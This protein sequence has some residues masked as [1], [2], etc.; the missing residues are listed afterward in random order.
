MSSQSNRRRSKHQ[1]KKKTAKRKAARK[2]QRLVKAKP[3]ANA[4]KQ[5]DGPPKTFELNDAG[6]A[7]RFADRCADTI[8]FCGPL[9]G[10]LHNGGPRWK[11]VGSGILNFIIECAR[12]MRFDAARTSEQCLQT[13]LYRHADRSQSS[14]RINACEKLARGLMTVPHEQ[15]DQKPHL[16]NVLNG[17]IDLRSGTLSPHD[18][19]DMLTQI[20]PVQFDESATCPRFDEFLSKFCLGR[21]DLV[22]YVLQ[23]LGYACTG[24]ACA[25]NL[26]LLLGSGDNGKSRLLETIMS[27]VLGLSVEGG[28]A[29]KLPPASLHRRRA[30]RPR[31]DIANLNRVRFAWGS[32][33]MDAALDYELIKEITGDET[34]EARRIWRD[35]MPIRPTWTILVATNHM[36]DIPEDEAVRRRLVVIPCEYKV[37]ETAN[38]AEKETGDSTRVIDP[39]LG[40]VLR[41]EASGI[42]LRLVL[43]AVAF[44]RAGMRLPESVTVREAG[45]SRSCNSTFQ[46]FA[47]DRLDFTRDGF[48]SSA[49]VKTS[50]TDW[51]TQE[52]QSGSCATLQVW[53]LRQCGVDR[54]VRR[55]G[56]KIVRGFRGIELV[57]Q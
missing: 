52:K 8:C 34:I 2:K 32:E 13:A 26:H 33:N 20:A 54:T 24:Y 50:F 4:D 23:T 21:R 35:F 55:V 37:Y 51:T 47:H 40:S 57:E 41:C 27:D 16:L 46:D 1:A 38:K 22:G 30:D 44:W 53:L 39:S 10:W 42:L 29:F 25:R 18:P 5:D 28:Y 17:T 12:S 31:F 48:V 14:A 7:E 3:K 43:G 36:P 11:P 19:S 15:F 49:D 6:D 56:K 45:E 9:G